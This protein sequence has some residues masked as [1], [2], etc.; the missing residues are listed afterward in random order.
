MTAAPTL[1][2]NEHATISRPAQESRMI[3]AWCV[4][5]A[6]DLMSGAAAT[7]AVDRARAPVTMAVTS[8]SRSGSAIAPAA[9]DT[10]RAPSAPVAIA[11]ASSPSQ[12]RPVAP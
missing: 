8:S 3:S 9:R 6:I 10:C 12:A 11:R 7:P 2:A 1:H 4:S 5:R